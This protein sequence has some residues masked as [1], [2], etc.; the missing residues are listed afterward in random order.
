VNLRIL[1]CIL[2]CSLLN[3]METVLSIEASQLL[4][5]SSTITKRISR[6][7]GIKLRLHIQVRVFYFPLILWRFDN[8][9]AICMECAVAL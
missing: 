2:D 5:V 6:L 9:G 3:S 7:Q 8:I 1:E 4:V